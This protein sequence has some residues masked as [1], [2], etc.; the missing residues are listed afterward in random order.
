MVHDEG[1]AHEGLAAIKAWKSEARRKYE[2]TV[3]P[4]QAA[5]RDGK[6]VVTA[7]VAATFPAARLPWR[8][9]S[10]S[11]ASRSRRW[12]STCER[13]LRIRWPSGMSVVC[14]REETNP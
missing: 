7:R 8:S 5:Q 10:R 14:L 4:L 1:R 13:A 3:E 6:T 12:R 9:S 11:S 2:Y